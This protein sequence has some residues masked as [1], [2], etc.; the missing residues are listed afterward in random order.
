MFAQT[1]LGNLYEDRQ[2]ILDSIICG[3]AGGWL[4]E[5]TP[6]RFARYCE[7]TTKHLGDLISVACTVNEPNIPTLLSF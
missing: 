1:M 3:M 7:R 6:E 5:K 4:D 2:F